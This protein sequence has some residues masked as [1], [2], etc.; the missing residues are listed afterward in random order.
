VVRG[1]GKYASPAL[2]FNKKGVTLRPAFIA[3]AHMEGAVP[4]T[5]LK[6]NKTDRL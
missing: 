6:L 2:D 1:Y 4:C 5:I 3:K